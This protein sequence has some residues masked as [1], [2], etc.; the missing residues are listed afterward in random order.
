M[1]A[2]SDKPDSS[3]YNVHER[4]INIFINDFLKNKV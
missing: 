2:S 4:P 1:A 3:K